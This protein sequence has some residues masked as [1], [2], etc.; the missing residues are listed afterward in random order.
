MRTPQHASARR[1]AILTA[2]VAV[3]ALTAI[4]PL[5]AESTPATFPVPS[6]ADVVETVA[7]S[8][9][10]ISTERRIDPAEQWPGFEGMERFFFRW[11][12]QPQRERRTESQGSG[13]IYSADGLILTNNHVVRGASD[14]RVGLQDGRELEA[15][16]VG[17]DESSDLAL[18][19]IDAD[20]LV[21]VRWADSGAVRVGDEVLALGNPFGLGETVTRG[22]VSA[23]GRSLGMIDYEDFL[24]TDAIIHPGN[25]GGPLVN[26]RGEVVGINTAI[27]S[28][29]GAGQ[30]IGF[31]IPSYLVQTVV[32]SL[33][34]HGRVVRGY[35]GVYPQQL[36]PELARATRVD[37]NRGVIV[38]RV[39]EDSPADASGLR[40]GD[41]IVGLDGNEITNDASFRAAIGHKAPG[42]DVELDVIR[43]GRPR[44][45][46][47]TLGERPVDPSVVSAEGADPAVE[48]GGFEV[49]D[50]DR[51]LAQRFDLDPAV[52][53][54]VVTR[55]QA[56]SSAA[57]AGLQPGDVVLEVNR[58]RV[59]DAD[60]VRARIREAWN[61]DAT[62]PVLLLVERGGA[63]LY[64]ALGPVE[65]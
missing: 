65:G 51:R 26:T 17:T 7:P 53:G 54:A 8:V 28:R 47:V 3:A 35:L 29:S 22:I 31:A 63:T 32:E 21:P 2:L 9:V 55:V 64:L 40:Q 20:G 41:V 58:T 44:T 37:A 4:A 27:L 49:E 12:D 57:R 62:A 23:K 38:S 30:G 34:D 24:Q 50:V 39:I 60:E 59:D 48:I 1:R 18:L 33:R 16:L 13:V 52:E 19:R 25:S 45:V 11:P 56:S 61:E 15:E 5:T 42:S 43:D 10:N 6:I 14:I 46:T 36:T